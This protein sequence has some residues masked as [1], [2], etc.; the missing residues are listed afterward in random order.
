MSHLFPNSLTTPDSSCSYVVNR[1]LASD[2]T[3][4]DC[5]CHPQFV[6]SSLDGTYS[7]AL[8]HFILKIWVDFPTH[9]FKQIA[10]HPSPALVGSTFFTMG[11]EFP[12]HRSIKGV[13]IPDW[14]RALCCFFAMHTYSGLALDLYY[15]PFRSYFSFVAQIPRK[16]TCFVIQSL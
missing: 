13:N 8:I 3:F 7:Q 6:C 16:F 14:S 1:K 12:C 15:S 5:W 10:D 9:P 4:Q 11:P 2:V